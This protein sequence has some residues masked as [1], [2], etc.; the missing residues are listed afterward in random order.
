MLNF[1]DLDRLIIFYKEFHDKLIKKRYGSIKKN[2]VDFSSNNSRN[3]FTKTQSDRGSSQRDR[4]KEIFL[5]IFER[6]ISCSIV[7]VKY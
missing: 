6:S 7:C 4:V 2:K 1:F 3:T 5:A